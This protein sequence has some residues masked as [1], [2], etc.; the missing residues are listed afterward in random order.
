[1]TL[2]IDTS[3]EKSEEAMK[4]IVPTVG[5]T[6]VEPGCMNCDVYRSV[7]NESF[8]VLSERWD[9]MEHFEHHVRSDCYRDVLAWIDM[10]DRQPEIHFDVV[11]RSEGLELIEN[12]RRK[13]QMDDDL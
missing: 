11:S 2:G 10:S 1:V 3:P 4:V 13:E 5:R 6:R 9:T 12:I 7:R 8:L